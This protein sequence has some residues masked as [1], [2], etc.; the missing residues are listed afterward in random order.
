MKV[1]E[2]LE[3]IFDLELFSKALL[4]INQYWHSLCSDAGSAPGHQLWQ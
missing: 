3:K 4:M 1:G 2:F